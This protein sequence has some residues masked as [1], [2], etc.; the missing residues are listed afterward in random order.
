MDKKELAQ[1]LALQYLSSSSTYQGISMEAYYEEYKK[2]YS[3]FSEL[4]EEDA[5][6]T[7][8]SCNFV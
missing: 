6:P 7:E 4:M 8:W 1:Q 3:K 5:E 2:A